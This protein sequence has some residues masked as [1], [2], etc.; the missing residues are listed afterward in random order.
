MVGYY[1]RFLVRLFGYEGAW[2]G[3][4]G[5]LLLEQLSDCGEEGLD[6]G[7]LGSPG[8][9]ETD[10]DAAVFFGGPF[11]EGDVAA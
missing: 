10:G 4:R 5:K 2:A 9:D 3:I 7:R 1:A 6:V 11:V 8:G